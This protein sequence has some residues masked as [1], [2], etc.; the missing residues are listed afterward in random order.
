M[1]ISQKSPAG[2]MWM[3]LVGVGLGCT[4]GERLSAQEQG[5]ALA[6]W[7]PAMPIPDGTVASNGPFVPAALAG[8]AKQA[9]VVA[10]WQ[11]APDV[12][13]NAIR[14]LARR[15][16]LRGDWEAPVVLSEPPNV[17][18]QEA[19]V[20]SNSS[21][22]TMVVW[23]EL[24]PS[25]LAQAVKARLFRPR[26]GWDDPVTLSERGTGAKVF[27][28]T[29]GIATATWVGGPSARTLVSRRFVPDSGWDAEVAV[30]QG[31]VPR[32][33]VL[34][35]D[36][37][38]NATAAWQDFNGLMVSRAAPDGSWSEPL[39][40]AGSGS[41]PLL[42]ANTAGQAVLVATGPDGLLSWRFE[43]ATGWGEPVLVPGVIVASDLALSNKGAATVV[44]TGFDGSAGGAST[45][46]TIFASFSSAEGTWTPVT[47]V[48]GDEPGIA[49]RVVV[50]SF[51]TSVVVWVQ[52]GACGAPPPSAVVARHLTLLAGSPSSC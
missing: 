21:G 39:R 18:G 16:S 15:Y 42:K 2:L 12:A 50:D 13:P 47:Q 17:G 52:G 9:V 37:Q 19:S 35:G 46:T 6:A 31:V 32:E 40:L 49:P 38:G 20:A 10:W 44:S 3:V 34:A 26:S 33:S 22:T 27:I 5:Q 23:T 36:G 4:G 1:R 30:G 41:F 8:S 43:P 14:L 45:A 51:G 7:S 11:P 29:S 28:D 25:T 24:N 48:S